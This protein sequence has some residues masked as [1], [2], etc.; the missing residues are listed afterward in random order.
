LRVSQLLAFGLE[1]LNVLRAIQLFD[2]QKDCKL[3][4]DKLAL[5]KPAPIGKAEFVRS[6]TN[7]S[8]ARQSYYSRWAKLLKQHPFLIHVDR[9]WH[10]LRDELGLVARAADELRKRQDQVDECVKGPFMSGAETEEKEKGA[11]AKR[12][13]G[14]LSN[15][16][17]DENTQRG[18][19]RRSKR[20]RQKQA[21]YTATDKE[22]RA[23]S[24]LPLPFPLRLSS[25]RL[26]LF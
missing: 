12:K 8:E 24:P 3:A 19:E 1:G 2:E 6:L 26:T 17:H 9:A 21:S 4:P 5:G 25:L 13:A 7:L 14:E 18:R 20:A 22:I 23:S 15:S 10:K 11:A 16:P